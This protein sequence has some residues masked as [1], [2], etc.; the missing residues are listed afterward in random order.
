MD[1]GREI[2]ILNGLWVDNSVKEGVFVKCYV[3][4]ILDNECN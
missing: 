4:H 3:N 1:L 2:E